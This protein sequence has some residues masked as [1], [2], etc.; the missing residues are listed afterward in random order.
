MNTSAER[1]KIVYH[2]R[3]CLPYIYNNQ[4]LRAMFKNHI[5]FQYI[6][7]RSVICIIFEIP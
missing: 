2:I 3:S 1:I 5:F 7:F 6:I 4:T